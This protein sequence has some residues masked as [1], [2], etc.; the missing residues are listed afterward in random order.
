MEYFLKRIPA[1]S[2]ALGDIDSDSDDDDSIVD[3]NGRD[4]LDN[5]PLFINEQ[6]QELNTYQIFRDYTTISH[7]I[8]AIG[9]LT[10]AFVTIG[11][12]IIH[13]SLSIIKV[14]YKKTSLVF[15]SYYLPD[16]DNT[17]I[18]F[19]EHEPKYLCY[20]HKH[21]LCNYFQRVFCRN[22]NFDK[23]KI[24][25]KDINV[26]CSRP[27]TQYSSK[28]KT[29]PPFIKCIPTDSGLSSRFP[30]LEEPTILTGLPAEA[31]NW[32]YFKS[33]PVNV[34]IVFYLPQVSI[35]EWSAVKEIFNTLLPVGIEILQK[36]FSSDNQWDN[37]LLC[38]KLKE[39]CITAVCNSERAKT[40]QMYT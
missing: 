35:C 40:D 37:K 29:P 12:G 27:V 25:I 13:K 11:T 19:I 3:Q 2:R 9:P 22:E 1:F 39:M 33:L 36:H 7:V 28:L 34:Y 6:D 15:K 16:Y 26:L 20:E 32:F 31:L 5:S 10:S 30:K 17:L 8:L 24:T 4:V 18:I 38:E 21:I 23:D 14:S